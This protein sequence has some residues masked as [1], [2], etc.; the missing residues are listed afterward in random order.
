MHFIK[1]GPC[2]P[3][4]ASS[5]I[6]LELGIIQLQ[7]HVT[8]ET[9]ILIR[10]GDSRCVLKV[11]PRSQDRSHGVGLKKVLLNFCVRVSY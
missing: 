5:N 4:A 2:I 8:F 6:A 7:L 9:P 10:F 11:R 3:P 1:I